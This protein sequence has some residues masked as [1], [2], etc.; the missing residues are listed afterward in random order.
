M[1]LSSNNRK[2]HFKSIKN[3]KETDLKSTV[4]HLKYTLFAL[5][6]LFGFI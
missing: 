1:Q 4:A 5:K 2:E 3:M 6:C